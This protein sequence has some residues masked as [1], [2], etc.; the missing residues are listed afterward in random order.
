MYYLYL[1]Y[2]SVPICVSPL[3]L[4]DENVF[5]YAQFSM[6]CVCQA[7]D[8]SILKLDQSYLYLIF[9]IFQ[10]DTKYD[11]VAQ[12][13]SCHSHRHSRNCLDPQ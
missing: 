7:C 6:L 11:H 9:L 10:N 2:V 3:V 1:V 8:R 13:Y 12:V 4:V 5:H